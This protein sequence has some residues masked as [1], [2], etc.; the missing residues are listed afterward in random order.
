[1]LGSEAS[2]RPEVPRQDSHR[3]GIQPGTPVRSQ[4]SPSPPGQ[5][6]QMVPPPTSLTRPGPPACLRQPLAFSH[7]FLSSLTL[8]PPKCFP[9]TKHSPPFRPNPS[10]SG[11]ALSPTHPQAQ[12]QA[13]SRTRSTHCSP[14]TGRRFTESAGRG[15]RSES[16]RGQQ[17]RMARGT[18]A[19]SDQGGP[20]SGRGAEGGS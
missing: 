8:L 5:G 14:G 2:D 1:M 18:G 12:G 16:W 11:E 7:P 13:H 19:E 3:A 4:T 9:S 10:P 20:L 15:P 17:H 6:H